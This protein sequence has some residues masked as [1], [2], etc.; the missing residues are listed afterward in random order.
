[1]T[2]SLGRK[3]LTLTLAQLCLAFLP[4]LSASALD[5]GM[6]KVRYHTDHEWKVLE[7][8]HFE[9][10]YYKECEAVARAATKYAE[11]DFIT[12]S[13]IFGYV[14]KNKIPLFIYGTGLEFQETNISP[15][16]LPEGVGG[17]TE[18]FKNRIAVPMTGSYFEFEK[19]LHHEMTHA[20]QYDLIYGEGWRSV[21]LFK[22]V[23]VPNWMMEGMAEWNAQHLDGQGE[24][25]LRDAILDD[26]TLPL[27]LLESFDHFEQVYMAYKESQSILDY[28]SQV[29]GHEKVM[30]IF[31]KMSSNMQPDTAVK[32]VLGVSQNTL[33][34]NWLFYMKSQ[35]WSR[36][37]GRPAPDRYGDQLEPGVAKAAVSPDGLKV[38]L[39]KRDQLDLWDPAGKKKTGLL[40]K[41]F[42][43]QGSG[44][45]WSPD[46]NYLA[47]AVDED[48]RYNLCVMEIKTRKV[49]TYREA[50]LPLVYSPAWSPNQ[51][52]LVFS[53]FDY[54][55]V[56]LYRLEVSSGNLERLSHDN[57][58]KSWANYSRD[59]SQLYY[60]D[61]SGGETTLRR[62][63]LDTAGLP[64]GKTEMIGGDLGYITSVSVGKDLVYFTSNRDN[65]IFNLFQ[66][67][68][69]GGHLIQLSK[70]FVDVLS[71]SPAPDGNIF[72][73]NL[74]QHGHEAL[75]AFEKNKL[76]SLSKPPAQLSYLSNSFE[77][78]GNVIAQSPPKEVF[79]EIEALST[80]EKTDGDEAKD[81][82]SPT[83]APPPLAHLEITEATNIVQLQWPVSF[84][85]LESVDSFRV[86]RSESA[87]A[88]F[89]YLGN[90][91][92]QRS[93][94][95]VDYDVDTG[96]DY[97]Y[98]VTAVNKAGESAPSPI[99]EAHP[100]M[101]VTTKDYQLRLSPDIL[102]LLA[103]YDS[104][105]GFVGGGIFQLSDYLG[106]HRLSILG[107]TVPSV[108]TG[109]QANYELSQWRTTVDMNF[110]YYQN[111]FN[112]YDL[113]S[114]NIVN[115]YRNN[116]NGASINFTYP[117]DMRNRFEY[118]VGTQ[119]FQGS[120]LYLQFSE[121]ISNYS[122]NNDEWHM[123]N[124]YRLSYVRDERQATQFWPSSGYALNLTLLHA[125]PVFDANVQ[126]A[127]ILFETQFF[128]DIGFLNHMVWAN[129]VIGMTSQGA[130]PQSFFIGDDAPFQAFFTTIRG[131]GAST[132]F[133]S[134]LGLFNTELRYP[135]ATNLNFIMHPLSFI[136][137]KDIELAGFLD[138]GVVSN[139]IQDLSTAPILGSI[140]TGIR[141]YAFVYQ[142]A[143]VMLRFDVAWRLD[144]MASP[145]FHFNLAPMF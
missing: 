14:P 134:N 115:E 69:E 120:P 109:V 103:G 45:A 7:T 121:G 86:Y 102:L 54:A 9:I 90:T 112:I 62:V 101:T 128:A 68:L 107:D 91:V 72:Y 106:D 131:Y 93:G 129:R 130:N 29:Y 77:R 55:T 18:V 28:V 133:G 110:F 23:F 31:K 53:G 122:L 79:K 25:V 40:H 43:I 16:L 144:E 76:E 125:L 84:G 61:E 87:G 10:Y 123:A 8:E 81:K 35:A 108:E 140:G 59:G 85:E 137:M 119:R 136:M 89:R 141:F 52:Y 26:Q 17:F 113:Q 124:F 38:A 135:L 80:P 92:N 114:G 97:F 51:K 37:K 44:V 2:G 142:R 60:V 83:Q 67:D 48:G 32:A 12:T 13:Q 3:F 145:T 57:D 143:L 30:Q 11:D 6:N 111:F 56:D 22:A 116:M 73:A 50:K 74:Y 82:K 64:T 41:T 105:A 71:A 70:T 34:D 42:Q 78:A 4:V 88:T 94:K 63:G 100:A 132:F 66:M 118:G 27:P 117:L 138:A 19:V 139:Q 98:Y 47:F 20:F 36:A 96:G 127:N 21:N 75:Y 49:T 126:F 46:G 15:Q 58:T 99:V 39:L 104:S 5:F 24:M 95:Y 65:R 1:M 33:Y